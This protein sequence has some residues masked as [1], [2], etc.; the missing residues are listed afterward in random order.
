MNWLPSKMIPFSPPDISEQDIHCIMDA[1]KSG[2]ITTGPKTKEFEKQI[3]LFCGASKAVCLS[4]ATAG[5]EL[6]LRLLGIGP[7]DEVITSAYT[8]SASASVI[9]HVGADIVLCDTEKDSCFLDIDSVEKA[10]TPK[11]KAVIPVDIGGMIFDYPALIALAEEKKRLFSP[12]TDWQKTIGRIAVIADAAHSFG[13]VRNGKQSGCE[14][15]FSC[16]SFHAV[17][18]LTTAEGGAIIWPFKPGISDED[19]YREFML[20]A[21]HGQSKDALSKM[22]PGAWEYDIVHLGYKYNM[23]DISA[24]LGLSQLAR[25]PEMLARREQIARI[26]D[27]GLTSCDVELLCHSG[28]D[29]ISNKHLYMTRVLGVDEDKRNSIIAQMAEKGIAT[30]VHFKP[31]PLFTAY[32][33][34]GFHITDF[35]N[36]YNRYCNEI[37]LP[38]YT[39]LADD[40][41][42]YVCETYRDIVSKI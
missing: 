8:Y 17:K 13:S 24:S 7:G 3:S 19:I 36:A 22:K 11:T 21:L 1:L 42:H 29:F 30:N 20:L 25:Y 4:S 27:N 10:I 15:D 16:F 38:L 31:L 41:A 35:P 12:K 40:D 23:T 5:M 9:A 34:R 28:K 18:N 37:T 14:A 2:W 39:K 6:T 33:K 32:K 26:Y